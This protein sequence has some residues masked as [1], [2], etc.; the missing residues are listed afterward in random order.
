MRGSSPRVRGTPETPP[1]NTALCRFI[2]AGAGNTL[3]PAAGPQPHSVH[4]RGCG[5][6]PPNRVDALDDDGSSPRVRGTPQKVILGVQLLRF[7]PAGAGNTMMRHRCR[8]CAP[9]H[10]RGCGEHQ[11]LPSTK[12]IADGSSPRVRGTRAGDGR[13]TRGGRFIPAGAGNTSPCYC[14]LARGPVHPRGCGE[15]DGA[16]QGGGREVRFIPAGAGNT[17]A[18]RAK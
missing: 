7:I 14:R 9:V 15:H 10:P 3:R 11:S 16:V 4:P 18:G 2:P 8:A 5:E 1:E 13:A 6:H 17:S 12:E